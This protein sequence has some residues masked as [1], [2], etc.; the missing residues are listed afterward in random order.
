M[1]RVCEIHGTH[2][3]GGRVSLH[4]AVLP[5]R[6]VVVA[7]VEAPRASRRLR[8]WEAETTSTSTSGFRVVF[9]LSQVQAPAA[10][11]A[12][13]AA[14]HKSAPAKM[15]AQAQRMQKVMK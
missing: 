3:F 10:A 2:M 12:G 8:T 4:V 9:G 7:R 1:L 14:A 15:H 13:A 5:R 11:R 6:A